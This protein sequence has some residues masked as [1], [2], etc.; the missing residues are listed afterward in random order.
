LGETSS[1]LTFQFRGFRP[2]R[3]RV[4]E[5]RGALAVEIAGNVEGFVAYRVP[6]SRFL[7]E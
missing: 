1:D 3:Y 4:S 6:D 7:V 5:Y 2:V